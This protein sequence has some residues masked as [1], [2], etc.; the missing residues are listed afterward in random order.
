MSLLSSPESVSTIS[1]L[2][3]ISVAPVF[4]LASVGALLGVFTNRLSRII[5]K[6]ESIDALL[7]SLGEHSH[8]M[9]KVAKL[10][11]QRQLLEKRVANMNVSIFLCTTTGIL[12]AFSIV[13][14]FM[15]TF[16]IFDGALLIAVLFVAGMVALVS[17]LLLFVREIILA[18]QF[19][20][21][22]IVY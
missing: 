2:I 14:I 9:N 4:L 6:F 20:K 17:A 1:H 18:T 21:R 19:V 16:F 11:Q 22:D 10:M 15:S 12:V 13:T 7:V 8:E 3:E 5:E